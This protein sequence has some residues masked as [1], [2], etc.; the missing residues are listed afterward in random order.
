[1]R[2]LK[3]FEEFGKSV[4]YDEI[5]D[6]LSEITDSDLYKFKVEFFPTEFDRFQN[7]G[8]YFINYLFLLPRLDFF[9][10]I[11]FYPVNFKSPLSA[12]LI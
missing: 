11:Y 5:K 7:G 8:C 4:T 2:H 10:R 6:I 1:V 12:D 9:R 3:I